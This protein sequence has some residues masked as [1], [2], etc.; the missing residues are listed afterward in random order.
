MIYD[1][2]KKIEFA[3]KFLDE[4]LG[5]GFGVLTKRDTDLLVFHLLSELGGLDSHSNHNLSLKL[6]IST[7]KIANYRLDRRLR[8][9]QLTEEQV[10]L[11]FLESLKKSAIKINNTSKWI[12]LSIEDSYVRESIKAKLK[13]LNHFSDSSFNAEII[14][15]DTEAFSDLLSD[16]YKDLK[17]DKKQYKEMNKHASDIAKDKSGNITVKGIFKA[18]LEG[19]AKEGGKRTISAGLSFLTGGASDISQ[20]ISKVKE[21]FSE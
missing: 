17:I 5:R 15:L 13:E 20:I 10:K 1:N 14:S 11:N 16:M 18:F 7:R 4:Y 8:Y 2:Q 9:N 21:Y 12:L 6:R 19:A 3:E